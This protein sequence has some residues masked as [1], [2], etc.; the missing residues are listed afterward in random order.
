VTTI[1]RVFVKDYMYVRT[2]SEYLYPPH[3]RKKKVTFGFQPSAL[4]G[5]PL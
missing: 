3:Y 1:R 5:L 4:P 2:C